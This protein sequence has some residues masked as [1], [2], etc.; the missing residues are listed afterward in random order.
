MRIKGQLLEI[1]ADS[2][3]EWDKGPERGATLRML[4]HASPVV[5]SRERDRLRHLIERLRQQTRWQIYV[6]VL[7]VVFLAVMLV[8]AFG[9]LVF[10]RYTTGKLVEQDSHEVTFLMDNLRQKA[11]VE[12]MGLEARRALVDYDGESDEPADNESRCRD[13]TTELI[14]ADN[15]V[16]MARVGLGSGDDQGD[17]SHLQSLCFVDSLSGPVNDSRMLTWFAA[18][19]DYFHHEFRSSGGSGIRSFDAPV[20]AYDNPWHSVYVFPPIL[21]EEVR[22]GSQASAVGELAAL[23]PVLVRDEENASSGSFHTVYFLS[24]NRMLSVLLG[25]EGLVSA[26]DTWWCV[27]NHQGRVIAA[28]ESMPTVGSLLQ[29]QHRTADSGPFAVASGEELLGDWSLGVPWTRSLFGGR[30][31]PWVVSAGQSPDLP[32]AILIGHEARELRTTSLGYMFAVIGMAL[33]AL[34]IAVFGVTRVVGKVSSRLTRLSRNMELVAEGDYSRRIP[35]STRDEVGLLINYFN[36]MAAS[37]DETQNQLTEKT[38][39]LQAALENRQLLDR[40]KDDFLE[41]ISHEVRTPLTAIMGGVN[42]LKSVV[43]RTLGADLE[44]LEKLNVIEV[45]KIIEGSGE[46]LHGFMN[47]AIQMTS[48]QSSDKEIELKI[49]S[50]GNLVELGLCGLREMAKARDIEVVNGLE[51]E[52]GWQ[53]LCDTKVMK[54]AFERILKNAVVHNYEKGRV[55]IREVEEVPGLGRIAEMPRAEDVHRL[56]SLRSFEPFEK[57]PISWRI[58]EIFNTGDAIPA[59]RCEALFGKFELV[60]RIEHH[61]RGSGLSLPIAQAAVEIHGGRICVHSAK[62]QGNS[63][64]LLLPTVAK[65]DVEVH[66]AQTE[67]GGLS[68]F[69]DAVGEQ[70]GHG[71]GGGTGDEYIDLVGDLAGLE[72]E[73]DDQGA[74][75]SGGG[76]QSG[77]RVDRAGGADDQ[78]NLGVGRGQR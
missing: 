10:T 27:L 23:L 34:A 37:L 9:W 6:R 58:V 3:A 2:Q 56:M 42:I 76:N 21:I 49:T 74:P 5:V 72:V 62:L 45:V 61:Q 25:S 20:L 66:R 52:R 31:A 12:I 75:A 8:G 47:D 32:L 57:I 18:N 30:L 13:W 28:A 19:H 41:L 40:A 11:L 22:G 59:E 44:V 14:R 71:V 36:Q 1:Q 68:L 55:V 24:L 67:G 46:R 15:L 39:H 64:Y 4:T 69:D 54:L 60:G 26:P 38:E 16:G 63:F 33:L 7:P 43:D 70:L 35:T 17:P 51:N 53:V 73:F 78:K 29:N 65:A 50:V 77:G 48:I